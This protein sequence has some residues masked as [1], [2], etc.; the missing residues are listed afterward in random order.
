LARHGAPESADT[1]ACPSGQVV[2]LGVRVV[3]HAELRAVGLRDPDRSTGG[4]GVLGDV[5][6]TFVQAVAGEIPPETDPA[7]RSAA[8]RV[9]EQVDRVPSDHQAFEVVRHRSEEHT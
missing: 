1:L 5:Y 4:E 8:L 9:V 3:L 6:A 2:H 7:V